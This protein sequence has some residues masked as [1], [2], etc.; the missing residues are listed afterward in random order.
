MA[1]RRPVPW[2]NRGAVISFTFD[3]FPRTA[4]TSG[5]EILKGHGVRGTY[6]AAMAMMGTM[7]HLGEQF[8]RE[9]LEVL[10]RDGHELAGHTYGHVSCR[11]VPLSEFVDD[12]R[13]GQS[14]IQQVTGQNEPANFAFPYGHVNTA[15]KRAV[16]RETLSARGTWGGPNG[17]EIDLNLLRANSLYG[18]IERLPRIQQLI[19]QNEQRG[20]WLIFYTHDVQ[21]M[22]SPYGCSPRL[23]ESAVAFAALHSARIL[24]VKE[25]IAECVARRTEA[26]HS[27]A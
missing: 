9:D 16:G 3:D 13:R 18:G 5:G 7:N 1:F 14:L 27:A 21:P 8:R 24:P 22:P 10:L 11:R 6:Y 4:L 17:P 19:L 25:V 23:L 15:G 26:V 12:M 20:G 2:I